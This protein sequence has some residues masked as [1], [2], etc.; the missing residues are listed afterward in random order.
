MRMPGDDVLPP[1]GPSDDETPDEGLPDDGIPDEEL[2]DD[3][4][5]PGGWFKWA[6]TH[7]RR[8]A[9]ISTEIGRLTTENRL[10]RKSVKTLADKVNNHAGQ[11]DQIGQTI[12]ARVEA[13]VLKRLKDRKR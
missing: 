9:N 10:L 7:A 4:T 5:L 6:F 1:D 3:E 11:L 2:P 12:E 8:L 13:E